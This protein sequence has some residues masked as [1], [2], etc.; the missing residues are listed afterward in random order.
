M[1]TVKISYTA[2]DVANKAFLYIVM[3]VASLH[4]FLASEVLIPAPTVLLSLYA[5]V[6]GIHSVGII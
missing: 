3:F 1:L 2:T 5:I 4:A 6:P